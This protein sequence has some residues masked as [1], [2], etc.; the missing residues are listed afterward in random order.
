MSNSTLVSLDVGEDDNDSSIQTIVIMAVIIGICGCIF[1]V[2]VAIKLYR[3]V[4]FTKL[5]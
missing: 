1:V 3:K 2:V 5:S 4:V